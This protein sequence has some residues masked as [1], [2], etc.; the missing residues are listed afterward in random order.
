M[1]RANFPRILLAAFLLWGLL[2]IGYSIAVYNPI[3][4]PLSSHDLAQNYG[5][6]SYWKQTGDFSRVPEFTGDV[7]YPP[8]YFV[9]L[10][11]FMKLGF[12][13]MSLL[14]YLLQF[15]LFFLA[16][17]WLVRAVS[18]Q[19]IPS[20]AEYLIA[21]AL[22]INFR[23]FVQTLS[24]HK[25]DSLVFALLCLAFYHLRRK[26]DLWAGSTIA[27]GAMLKYYPAILTIHFLL[28]RKTKVLLGL[29]FSVTAILLFLHLF[30]KP[31]ELW[32]S[33]L[34]PFSALSNPERLYAYLT[35]VSTDAE[36]VGDAILKWFYRPAPGST[37]HRHLIMG[38]FTNL[39]HPEL[40]L[41][42]VALAKSFF[43]LWYLIVMVPKRKWNR[44]VSDTA[45]P[46]LSLELSLTLLL[47]P[48]ATQTARYHYAILLLPAFL[49]VALL[50]YSD[51][52]LFR[53]KEKI[54]FALS[55]I[56]VGMPIPGGLLN[57]VLPPSPI[58]GR[59]YAL[60]YEWL[61]LPVYGFLLLFL[62]ILLCYKRLGQRWTSRR[63][64]GVL[65]GV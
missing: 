22:V 58:W 59:E 61:S 65:Q 36:S 4:N 53:L 37:F 19:P 2:R 50:L 29:F 20:A 27:L 11:P 1:I 7:H 33:L 35:G 31:Q 64:E 51:G 63:P 40:A 34:F 26:R 8:L 14:F 46:L 38:K 12:K 52:S 18:S 57:T 30:L 62:C 24:Y 56:L 42:L 48:I 32:P 41:T 43:V 9:T 54:L 60:M 44:A 17:R 49:C 25:V 10:L 3:V 6:L 28:K 21:V 15:P 16:I 13:P 47:L 23:P 39:V 5:A 55:Y 45:W